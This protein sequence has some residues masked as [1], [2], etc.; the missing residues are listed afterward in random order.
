VVCVH[1]TKKHDAL[2]PKEQTRK[3]L[4]DFGDVTQ[5]SLKSYGIIDRRKCRAKKTTES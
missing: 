5:G 3:P 4:F 1:C 2:G